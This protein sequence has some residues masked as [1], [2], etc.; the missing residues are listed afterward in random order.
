MKKNLLYYSTNTKIA[1]FISEQFYN[2]SHF[3]WCAPVYD[4]QKLDRYDFRSKIPISSSPYKIYR[5]LSDEVTTGDRHSSKI[6]QN[7]I[8]LKKGAAIMREKG[9]I[10][11]NDF[12]RIISIIDSAELS[13]FAPLLYLI[14]EQL[15][16]DKIVAVQIESAANPLSPEFQIHELLRTEF[17][18]IELD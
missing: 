8:G 12:A 4:P 3:V 10:D 16:S 14:P 5:Q 6:E 7:K 1:F 13:E 18:I 17:E 15:V 11:D 9:I 2:S